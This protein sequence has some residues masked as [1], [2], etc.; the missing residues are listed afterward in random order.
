MFD[1]LEQ[2]YREDMALA[3]ALSPARVSESSAA[4]L[5]PDAAWCRRCS[6]VFGN[7]LSN[8]N[9]RRAHAVIT[10][11]AGGEGGYA[12]SVRAPK[13]TPRGAA[14]LCKQFPSGGGRA[15]AAGINALPED[16]LEHFLAAFAA[17]YS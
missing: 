16:Q 6:G 2:G 12:V 4:Y 14:E 3:A 15:G 7:A 9:P 8:D 1:K 13:S 17:Q 5:L 10:P 11:R